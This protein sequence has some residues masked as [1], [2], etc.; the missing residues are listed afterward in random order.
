[1]ILIDTSFSPDFRLLV[2]NDF[3]GVVLYAPDDESFLL[4]VIIMP[5]DISC[6]STTCPLRKS[7]TLAILTA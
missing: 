5:S 7:I 3:G 4:T 6:F 1:M 2:S